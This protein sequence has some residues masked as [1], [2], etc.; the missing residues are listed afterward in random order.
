[1]ADVTTFVE[2]YDWIM[3]DLP[4]ALHAPALVDR[5]LKTAL[6]T[7]CRESEAW[8]QQLAPIS[9][10]DGVTEYT[11]YWDFCANAKRIHEVKINTAQGV[12][13]GVEGEKQDESLYHMVKPDIIKLKD[14]IKPAADITNALDVNLILVPKL[15]ECSAPVWFVNDWA[16][17]IIAH[18]TWKLASMK[19]AS[20][21][22]VSTAATGRFEY[23]QGLNEAKSEAASG[24]KYT[25]E[26]YTLGG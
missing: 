3:P 23:L 8:E 16:E 7:F 14:A 1:M 18:A 5:A 22:D 4:G 12:T 17:A 26:P 10:K 19:N 9:L 13:D 24:N 15:G 20:W 2:F 25:E 21:A 11:M 6:R